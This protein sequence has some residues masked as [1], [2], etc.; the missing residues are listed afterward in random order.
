MVKKKRLKLQIGSG[1]KKVRRDF[2][3]HPTIKKREFTFLPNSYTYLKI[4]EIVYIP[5]SVLVFIV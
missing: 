3:N 4:W 1:K 2:I 5:I